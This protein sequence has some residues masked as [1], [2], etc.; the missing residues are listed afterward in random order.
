MNGGPSLFCP[1]PLPTI[2]I[3]ILFDISSFLKGEREEGS[4]PSYVCRVIFA[5]SF[6]FDPPPPLFSLSALNTF[7]SSPLSAEIA[8][9]RSPTV[10]HDNLRVSFSF[11]LSVVPG[12][13]VTNW[14]IYTGKGGGTASFYCPVSKAGSMLFEGEEGWQL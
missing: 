14:R 10:R 3:T 13:Q 8:N 9:G 11:S 6:F 2:I 7:L 4:F 5:K 1:P 12:G